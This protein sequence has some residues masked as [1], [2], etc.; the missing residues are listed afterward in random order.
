LRLNVA[1]RG[2]D[3]WDDGSRAQELL[4]G[5]SFRDKATAC[6]PQAQAGTS[7][8]SDWIVA[9]DP[10][11]KERSVF[12]APGSTATLEV[13]RME[14]EQQTSRLQN[15]VGL[16]LPAGRPGHQTARRSRKWI[17]RGD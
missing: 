10:A 9:A 2:H 3:S 11:M 14:A 6:S 1:A 5:R 7:G 17:A 4:V 15:A 16:S 8:S 12:A 13:H